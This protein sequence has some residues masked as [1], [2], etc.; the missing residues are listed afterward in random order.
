MVKHT[1]NGTIRKYTII[2]GKIIEKQQVF[3][4]VWT[5]VFV[6]T[7]VK[8]INLFWVFFFQFP[9]IVNWKVI[10]VIFQKKSFFLCF[11]SLFPY[12]GGV[13]KIHFFSTFFEKHE[14]IL[15]SYSQNSCIFDI[16]CWESWHFFVLKM[17]SK[18]PIAAGT[19]FFGYLKNPQKNTVFWYKITDSTEKIVEK[20]TFFTRTH[21]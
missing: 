4:V 16:T 1:E 21:C 11:S 6:F 17:T 18:V 19:N 13:K 5:I 2:Y 3:T 8:L 9:P 7:M 14:K 12:V 15:K 10:F 20:T